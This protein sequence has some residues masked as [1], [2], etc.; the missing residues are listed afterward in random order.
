MKLTFLA[1]YDFQLR[2]SEVAAWNR[3]DE[4]SDD[5]TRFNSMSYRRLL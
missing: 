2:Q 3:A 1:N 5:N 4:N